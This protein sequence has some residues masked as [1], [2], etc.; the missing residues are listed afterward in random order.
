MIESIEFR[1]PPCVGI[2]DRIITQCKL[3]SVDV[4]C[5]MTGKYI[6]TVRETAWLYR[7]GIER[8]DASHNA[9]SSG[10]L[11]IR[12][13]TRDQ[14]SASL[15]EVVQIEAWLDKCPAESEKP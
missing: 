10:S 7:D 6:L 1:V 13:K 4:A 15:P 3:K 2:G 11:Q 9:I 5:V 8:H 14:L 12:C